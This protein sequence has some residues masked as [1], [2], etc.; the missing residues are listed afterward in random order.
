MATIQVDWR[1]QGPV[2]REFMLST[3]RIQLIM[4][5]LGSAKTNTCIYKLLMEMACQQAPNAAGIRPTRWVIV[6]NTYDDLKTN[7]IADWREMYGASGEFGRLTMGN[8]P[9]FNAKFS[10]EDGTEVNAEFIFR[11]LDR[12]DDV[13]RIRGGNYTG[14]WMNE[15]KELPKAALDMLDGRVG[16]YPTSVAGGV[17]CSLGPQ[18][19]GRG[20]GVILGDYNA[21]DEDHWIYKLEQSRPEG[22]AFFRQ[23][24]GVIKQGGVYVANPDAENI[25]NLPPNYYAGRMAG[26]SEDWIKVN[27][28][29]EYGL[30]NDGRPVFSD[31]SDSAHCLAFDADPALP[32]LLGWDAGLTPACIVAQLSKRGQLRVIEE[33]CAEDMGMRRFARDVVKPGLAKYRGYTI[34]LSWGDPSNTRGDADEKRAIGI[35]NDDY[36]ENDDGD[37]IQALDMGFITEPASTNFITPRL[38]AVRFYLTMMLDGAP[39][40]VIHPR[41]KRLR[42]ALSGKYRFRRLKVVGEEKYTDTP[43]KNDWSHPADALQYLC[44]GAQGGYVGEAEGGWDTD[45]SDDTRDVHTGY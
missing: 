44:L 34:G 11:S 37:Q 33:F 15:A 25:Q 10:I 41:C 1:P 4:G 30:V 27:L 32:L 39:G 36:V 24:G 45:L 9:A 5:P 7:T 19:D 38:E 17:D 35:L 14:A 20:E 2:L 43:E 18:T 3:A 22:Y 40:F 16:R 42:Q 12:P 28:A 21:P 23:P 31:Y 13:K 8:P 29:N 6:R 26:K